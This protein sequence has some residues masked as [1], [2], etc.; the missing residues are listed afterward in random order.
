MALVPSAKRSIGQ[1]SKLALDMIRKLI[2]DKGPLERKNLFQLARE[3]KPSP[4]L[5]EREFKQQSSRPLPIVAPTELSSEE[6]NKHTKQ[7]AAALADFHPIK[8]MTHLKYEI[9]PFLA[10]RGEIEK[11]VDKKDKP[12]IPK[13]YLWRL[14][15][16]TLS[17]QAYRKNKN[18]MANLR[19]A[20]GMDDDISHLN[21]R[22]QRVRLEKMKE[23]LKWAQKLAAIRAQSQYEKAVES[24]RLQA[25]RAIEAKAGKRILRLQAAKERRGNLLASPT[26][27]GKEAVNAA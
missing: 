1:P 11:I 17:T 12:G 22:R 2:A 25:V 9:L 5:V 20:L 23:Q 15:T 6:H 4:K 7:Q 10:H 13:S 8:S 27:G 16:P 21:R 19:E 3:I 18:T 24:A 14:V 26:L